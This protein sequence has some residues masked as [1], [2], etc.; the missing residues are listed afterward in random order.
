M[1]SNPHSTTSG[2]TVVG[3]ID[4]VDSSDEYVIADISADDAWISMQADDA[5]T[6]RAWR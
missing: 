2:E 4:T 6:L 1:E 5:S 3:S